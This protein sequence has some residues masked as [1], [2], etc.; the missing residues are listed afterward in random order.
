MNP[1]NSMPDL[2]EGFFYLLY[3]AA[4]KPHVQL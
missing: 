3:M 2:L 4:L 1:V